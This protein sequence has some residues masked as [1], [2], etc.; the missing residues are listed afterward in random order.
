MNG[1][2]VK[3][4]QKLRSGDSIYV[5]FKETPII[6]VLPEDIPLDILYEDEAIIAVNK[7][8]GMVVHPAPGAY[9]G[10]FANALLHHCKQIDADQFDE[11]RPGIVHRLDKNTTGV[12]VAAKTGAAHKHLSKQFA[13]RSVEKDYL[14]ICA[15]VPPEGLFSAPIKRHPVKRIQMAIDDSGKEAISHFTLVESLGVSIKAHFLKSYQLSMSSVLITL[16]II[17]WT[18]SDFG[19]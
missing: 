15:G 10:T 2:P 1:N 18:S 12:L 11:L 7:P 5:V 19:V 16:R 14:A 9:S 8:C 4:R 17:C 3:K 6:D 13:D